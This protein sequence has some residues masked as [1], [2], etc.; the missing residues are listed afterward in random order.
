MHLT[1]LQLID[2]ELM[3]RVEFIQNSPL[4]YFLI[5][6]NELLI[7]LDKVYL[8]VI[9][10]LKRSFKRKEE[11]IINNMQIQ[12][13]YFEECINEF[14]LYLNTIQIQPD[15]FDMIETHRQMTWKGILNIEPNNIFGEIQNL[16]ETYLSF[17]FGPKSASDNLGIPLSKYFSRFNNLSVNDQIR[18]KKE[19]FGTDLTEI[20]D[21]LSYL[22]NEKYLLENHPYF[23]LTVFKN[24]TSQINFNYANLDIN[25]NMIGALIKHVQQ[26]HINYMSNLSNEKPSGIEHYKKKYDLDFKRLIHYI[27]NA[28]NQDVPIQIALHRYKEY[29]EI[30]EYNNV[31]VNIEGSEDIS[32]AE[33]Y[34]NIDISKYLHTF[35]FNP[36]NEIVQGNV[37][38]DVVGRSDLVNQQF[39]FWL[40]LKVYKKNHKVKRITKDMGQIFNYMLRN[41][42]DE[43][44]LIIFLRCKGQYILPPY[45]EINGKTIHI[46][47]IDVRDTEYTGSGS[48]QPIL[49]TVNEIEKNLLVDSK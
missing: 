31:I 12:V 18:Q 25:Q 14:E 3:R 2:S 19:K 41:N 1:R 11:K 6:I 21:H 43:G 23:L 22:N 46:L 20:N 37:I 27:R 39:D 45:Y 44:Y 48:E 34:Y 16:T 4:N 24:M 5:E 10:D 35:G 17:Y 38:G 49:I 26:K 28:A 15:F 40:E 7:F 13:E 9:N 42:L 47:Q 30:Y 33:V 32:S 36:L 29:K 8:P